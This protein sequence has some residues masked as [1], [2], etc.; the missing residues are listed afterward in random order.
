MN[1]LLLV[2]LSVALG[3]AVNANAAFNLGCRDKSKGEFY[4]ISVINDQIH[5]CGSNE[6]GII[7]QNGEAETTRRRLELRKFAE[8][9]PGRYAVD[10]TAG[11]EMACPRCI[12][13]V[14][15]VSWLTL[16]CEV[17]AAQPQACKAAVQGPNPDLGSYYD[18]AL[19]YGV[20]EDTWVKIPWIT[21]YSPADK[22]FTI[23]T[24]NGKH[25][26]EIYSYSD[27]YYYRAYVEEADFKAAVAAKLKAG[28]KLHSYSTN[29]EGLAAASAILGYQLR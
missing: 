5:F 8:A 1:K 18:K 29:K 6:N 7:A 17:Q 27:S 15:H 22:S 25:L 9:G 26:D 11:Y 14:E 16:D 13:D 12:G 21:L 28:Q 19:R 3:A 20:G 10:F 4:T 2:T 24:F 23:Y